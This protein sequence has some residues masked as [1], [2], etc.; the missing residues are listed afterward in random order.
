MGMRINISV[1][2]TRSYEFIQ[3]MILMQNFRE[4]AQ[5]CKKQ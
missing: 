1:N 4:R 2:G 5:F 3:A